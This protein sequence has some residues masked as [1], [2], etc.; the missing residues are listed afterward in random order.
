MK[1]KLTKKE[2]VKKEIYGVEEVLDIS[3]ILY[4]NRPDKYVLFHCE[5]DMFEYRGS[6]VELE[7]ILPDNFCRVH[8][9]YIVNLDYVLCVH[10]NYINLRNGRTIPIA[11][12]RQK[13]VEELIKKY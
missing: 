13:Y 8:N 9:E 10:P 12:R 1:L 7:N 4:I 11:R 2:F 3:Q 6:L 5:D